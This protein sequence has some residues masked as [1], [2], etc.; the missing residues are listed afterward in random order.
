MAKS[1]RKPAPGWWERG[2]LSHHFWSSKGKIGSVE[3]I[4][5]PA[6]ERVYRWRCIAA[7]LTGVSSDLALAKCAIEQLHTIGWVQP[8]L[9][10]IAPMDSALPAEDPDNSVR[11][12]S[13]SRHSRHIG[14]VR[15]ARAKPDNA[16]KRS[17]SPVSGQPDMPLQPELFAA[18]L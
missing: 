7:N 5:G 12:F 15:T 11:P 17:T 2:Y 4:F 13:S 14:P 9:E 8:D 1:R 10:G 16:A 3:L 18:S 6:G